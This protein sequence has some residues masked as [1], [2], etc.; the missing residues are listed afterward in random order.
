[1]VFEKWPSQMLSLLRMGLAPFWSL[2][3]CAGQLVVL[4]Q[5]VLLEDQEEG[6]TKPGLYLAKLNYLLFYRTAWSPQLHA[7]IVS[8]PSI[9]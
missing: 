9:D 5:L 2:S 4:V 8:L 7:S 1:M 3:I 6:S